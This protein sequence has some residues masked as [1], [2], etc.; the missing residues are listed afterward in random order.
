M[1]NINGFL[2]NAE[3]LIAF[4][5]WY[6]ANPLK[7]S[8]H[9][10]LNLESVSYSPKDIAH[11]KKLI[12]Y[13]EQHPEKLAFRDVILD[14]AEHD[15]GFKE[16]QFQGNTNVDEYCQDLKQKKLIPWA[17]AQKKLRQIK[18]NAKQ[19][20]KKDNHLITYYCKKS[21]KRIQYK[22]FLR[23]LTY[24]MPYDELHKSQTFSKNL[25]N[26]WETQ[27]QDGKWTHQQEAWKTINGK[28]KVVTENVNIHPDIYFIVSF[29]A[30]EKFNAQKLV[31][32]PNIF[33]HYPVFL[34]DLRDIEALGKANYRGGE[35]IPITNPRE[36]VDYKM[37]Q[38]R[39]STEK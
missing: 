29:F 20:I 2:I 19:T 4:A 35:Q 18:N 33:A 12:Q 36:I 13:L 9:D 17:K 37:L 34:S 31:F 21:N 39:K 10:V 16:G 32:K 15:H 1:K 3:Q 8:A 11:V 14:N 26:P 24:N 28:R 25:I 38:E 6:L 22:K 27:Y 23:H 30:F 5:K 7:P